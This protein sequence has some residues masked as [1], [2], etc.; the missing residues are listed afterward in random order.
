[1]DIY[2]YL[3]VVM[4]LPVFVVINL[5]RGMKV[6]NKQTKFNWTE[7]EEETEREVHTHLDMD[8]TT[9]RQEQR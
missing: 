6:D 8:R 1:M 2:L 7:K 4:L 5:K 3:C 9:Q